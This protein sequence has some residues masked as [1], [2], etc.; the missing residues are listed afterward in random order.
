[1]QRNE[2][3][4]TTQ[5]LTI[6]GL[7]TAI[8][9]FIPMIMPFKVVIGPASFTL[10]SHVP[11]DMAMFRKPSTA[12]IV[13]IG[14]TIGFLIAGFPIVIVARALTHLIF[15]TIGAYYLQKFPKTLVKTASRTIFS[16]WVNVL[17]G[18]GEVAIV[19]IL[20]ATGVSAPSDGFLY[21]LI[22]LIGIGTLVHGMVDFEISYQITKAIEK[23][24]HL[25][26]A[27]VEL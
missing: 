25:N 2:V 15:A 4:K 1:M 20:T 10:G 17:H 24:A 8:G 13:A 23:R 3:K 26:F 11:V 14:T 9:I 7:L 18:L 19:Y 22:V 16:L 5:N 27:Q 6:T 21:T 12:A